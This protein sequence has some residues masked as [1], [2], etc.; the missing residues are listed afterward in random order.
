[1]AGKPISNEIFTPYM[2][3][4]REDWAKLR[5]QTPLSLTADDICKL[6]GVND[7]LSLDEVQDVYLPLSRLLNMYVKATQELHGAA[8]TFFGS[9][10]QKVPY[11]IGIAGSVAVG[12]STTARVLKALL[13]RWPNHPKVDLVTTDGFLYPNRILEERGI[14]KRKGF[15]ESYDTK[16]LLRFLIDVKSGKPQLEC[17]IYSH[18][19]YDILQDEKQVVDRPDVLIVEGLNVLQGPRVG[20]SDSA[21]QLFVSDFFDFSIYVDAGEQHIER[22][23][24]ERFNVLR[25]TAFRQPSSYFKRYSGLTK[26]E[27]EAVAANIWKEINLA[28]LRAN[29][30]PTKYRAHL[31]L[32]KQAD[33]SVESVLLRKL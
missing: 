19:T 2:A 24:I 5:D 26:E 15:P 23:Y 25:E 14:M 12:K 9:E 17:P 7:E 8:Q 13:S 29:I 33:H 6:R 18:L 20:K 22:W 31:I 28:N 27:G 10:A 3:F 16:R 4:M 30:L 32:K 21:P 11:I 1:M